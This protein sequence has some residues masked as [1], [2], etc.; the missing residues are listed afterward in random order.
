MSSEI[1]I[2]YCTFPDEETAE[3]ICEN[4]VHEGFV[5]CANIFPAH[6]A[7]YKWNGNLQ[8]HKES[9]VIM[10]L[11]AKNKQKLTEKIQAAHPYDVPA[12]V[13]WQPEDGLP[14]YL[15]WICSQSL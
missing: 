2:A 7:I 8:N 5:A 11:A 6:K 13:F 3:S 15:N 9:A 12:L 14:D 4:L 10:K 1:L